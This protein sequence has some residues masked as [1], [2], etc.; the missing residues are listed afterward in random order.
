M[1]PGLFV[2]VC[3]LEFYPMPIDFCEVNLS[4]YDC[5]SLSED[6]WHSQIS[7]SLSL[8]ILLR[9]LVSRKDDISF[10]SSFSCSLMSKVLLIFILV[11]CCF[12]SFELL[13]FI[14]SRLSILSLSLSNSLFIYMKLLSHENPSIWS[15]DCLRASGDPLASEKTI[16]SIKSSS[17]FFC[18]SCSY[19]LS[20]KMSLLEGKHKSL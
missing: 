1:K 4:D 2:S 13:F 6:S 7:C 19:L 14:V 10:Y 9:S 15:N 5:E 18:R 17:I 16:S 8:V 12:S 20:L 3:V 11:V